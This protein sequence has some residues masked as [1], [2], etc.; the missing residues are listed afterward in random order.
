MLNFTEQ[1]TQY[2]ERVPFINNYKIVGKVTKVVGLI[3]E[4]TLPDATLGELC[5]IYRRNGT[6]IRA[7]VVGFVKI[8]FC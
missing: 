8:E 1:L 2:S 4:A 7:E 6:I 3:I 5:D